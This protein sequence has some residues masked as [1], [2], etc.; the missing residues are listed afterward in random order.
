LSK[1]ILGLKSLENKMIKQKG[2]K[3]DR[4]GSKRR[5]SFGRGAST[6]TNYKPILN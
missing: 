6:L 1:K 5:S 2:E 3:I 4:S